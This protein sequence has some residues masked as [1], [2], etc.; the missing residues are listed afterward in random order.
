M[1]IGR[2]NT[3]TTYLLDQGIPRKAFHSRGG[4]PNS[5]STSKKVNEGKEILP[6]KMEAIEAFNAA[7]H[8]YNDSYG[9]VPDEVA[10]KR[11]REGIRQIVESFPPNWKAGLLVVRSTLPNNH[12]DVSYYPLIKTQS[13]Y[14]VG[15]YYLRGVKIYEV[16]W[17]N[18]YR[19]G[20]F[21]VCKAQ[22]SPIAIWRTSAFWKEE[23]KL[24]DEHFWVKHGA[25]N[26]PELVGCDWLPLN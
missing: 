10:I 21:P 9:L 11:W 7:H 3:H 26:D 23:G 25:F 16:N 19:D 22:E 13:G 18:I 2:Q 6:T 5:I 17:E 15:E 14:L 8:F 20:R 24:W 12:F 4:S 1:E